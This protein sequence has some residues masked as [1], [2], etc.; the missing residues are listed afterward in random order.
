[1]RQEK[2]SLRRRFKSFKYAF[3]GM[4]ILFREEPN[5]KIHV[6]I[7]VGVLVAGFVFRISAGEWMAVLLCIGWVI[8]LEALNSAIENISDFVSPEK[9][10]MI[11]KIKDLA[12]GAVLL[13]V[14]VS[15]IVGLIVF[16][17]KIIAVF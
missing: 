8:A 14:I 9:H 16:L 1:M 11:K 2:D 17:P 6:F 12:A 13:G 10:E 3:N 15:V 4:K 7:S 5:A